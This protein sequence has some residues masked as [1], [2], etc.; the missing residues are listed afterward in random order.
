V[1]P[2]PPPDDWDANTEVTMRYAEEVRRG[3]VKSAEQLCR[4]YLAADND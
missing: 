2:V 3:V 1:T 4:E